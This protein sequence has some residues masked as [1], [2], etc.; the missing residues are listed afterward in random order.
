MMKFNVLRVF[1]FSTFI[2]S[3]SLVSYGGSFDGLV[4]YPNPVRVDRG[5][6]T[7]TFNGVPAPVHIRIYNTRGQLVL[8]L[9]Q[10]SGTQFTWNLTNDAG[11]PVAPGVYI[12]LLS[13]A[14]SKTTRGKC[15]VVR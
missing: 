12:Y 8:D 1:F 10:N 15:A 14:E 4:V 13:D 7:I 6:S 9:H 2:L 11:Q 5:Q 3:F